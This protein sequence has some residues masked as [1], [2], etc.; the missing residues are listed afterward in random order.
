MLLFSGVGSPERENRGK[1]M[2]WQSNRAFDV[3]FSSNF[4]TL[5]EKFTTLKYFQVSTFDTYNK[6]YVICNMSNFDVNIYATY[7]A[8]PIATA[9]FAPG[10][11]NFA[12][13]T[14]IPSYLR[15]YRHILPILIKVKCNPPMVMTP[16]SDTTQFSY[17][18]STLY[19][20]P[21]NLGHKSI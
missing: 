4:Q 9:R 16:P 1:I 2:S 17:H 5:M 8:I 13:F 11:H 6:A 14:H 19:S 18:H 12:T 3:F 20:K 21:W 7:K 10:L 15:M